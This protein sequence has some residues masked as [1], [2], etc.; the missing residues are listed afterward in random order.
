MQTPMYYTPTSK[1]AYQN[2]TPPSKN[3]HHPVGTHHTSFV[4]NSPR[5]N[6]D[7]HKIDERPLSHNISLNTNSNKN[8]GYAP[9]NEVKPYKV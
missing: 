4:A 1:S 8:I 3:D 5:S 7:I 9:H 6:F 2:Y